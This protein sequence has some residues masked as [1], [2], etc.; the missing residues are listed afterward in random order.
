MLHKLEDSGSPGFVIILKKL[1]CP[2]LSEINLSKRSTGEISL[3]S[4]SGP[5]NGKKDLGTGSDKESR[6][7]P[8]SPK[9]GT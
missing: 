4:S 1:Q 8:K 5:A 3:C 6:S 2:L 7:P 9:R